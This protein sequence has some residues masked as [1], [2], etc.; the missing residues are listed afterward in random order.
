MNVMTGVPGLYEPKEIFTIDPPRNRES[1]RRI[2]E[3]EP[4]LACF[5]HGPPLR[6]PRKIS[7]FVA[8]LP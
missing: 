6:N 3:L 1:A 8:R 7:E 4:A 5:G 2:A